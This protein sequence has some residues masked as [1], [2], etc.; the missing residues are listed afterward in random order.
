MGEG[1]TKDDDETEKTTATLRTTS[2]LMESKMGVR[3]LSEF[4]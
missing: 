3:V 1:S 2:G 4:L